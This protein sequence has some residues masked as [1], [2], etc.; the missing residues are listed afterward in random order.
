MQSPDDTEIS[1]WQSCGK[2]VVKLCL[3]GGIVVF[4]WWQNDARLQTGIFRILVSGMIR[5]LSYRIGLHENWCRSHRLKLAPFWAF[6]SERTLLSRKRPSSSFPFIA[7]HQFS[8][9][10]VGS[11]VV[12]S[13]TKRGCRLH[14]TY[15]AL[16]KSSMTRLLLSPTDTPTIQHPSF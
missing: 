11:A 10:V 8:L 9:S 12:C 5:S 2:T 13:T 1:L 4:E 14:A 16:S 15:W 3:N 6:F 7:R